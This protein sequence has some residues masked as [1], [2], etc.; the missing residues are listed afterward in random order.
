MYLFLK[1]LV[2]IE[3]EDNLFFFKVLLYKII[4]TEKK[5]HDLV[6]NILRKKN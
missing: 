6:Y 1:L 3:Q 5:M 4:S 2:K